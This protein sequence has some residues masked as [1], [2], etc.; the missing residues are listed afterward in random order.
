[1]IGRQRW[2]R[3]PP[4]GDLEHQERDLEDQDHFTFV[5]RDSR[6]YGG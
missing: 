4:L 6:D 3:S 1:M 2:A 5:R